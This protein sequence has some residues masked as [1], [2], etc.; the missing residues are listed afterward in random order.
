MTEM[1]VG[2]GATPGRFSVRCRSHICS[3]K[4]V[5]APRELCVEELRGVIKWSAQKQTLDAVSVSDRHG[6]ALFKFLSTEYLEALP[7]RRE[8][9]ARIAS[10]LHESAALKACKANATAHGLLLLHIEVPTDGTPSVTVRSEIAE[11][12][13]AD[14]VSK[15][16]LAVFNDERVPP[17]FSARDLPIAVKL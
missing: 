6:Q 4:C 3:V 15:A 9:L 14:C 10:R 5:T 7:A 16:L 8:L 11:T 1:I 12:S 2:A 13:D 17:P